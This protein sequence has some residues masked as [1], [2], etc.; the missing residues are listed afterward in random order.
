MVK[1]KIDVSESDPEEAKAAGSFEA[2]KPG[3]Y[4]FEIAEVNPGFS[5]GD[6]GKPDNNKPRLEVVFK[7]L[8]SRFKGAQV[9]GYF[10]Q[11]GHP[12][13]DKKAAEKFDQLLLAVKFTDGKKNR[14]AELDTDKHLVGKKVVVR[15]RAGKNQSGDARGEFGSVFP[16]ETSTGSSDTTSATGDDEMIEGD[17]IVADEIDWDAR[18]ADLAGADVPSLKAIAK[19]YEVKITGMKKSEVVDAILEYE[20]ANVSDDDEI[21]DDDDEIIPDDDEDTTEYLT[22][23]GL[24]AMETS[25]I[26]RIAKED[27][28]LTIKGKRK[29]EVIDMIIEAQA[30]PAD[31]GDE[32]PF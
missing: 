14:V 25:E 26:A 10:I 30:A 11:K 17:D 1:I 2:I 29:S 3:L 6:D 32:E 28:D 15:V 12:G 19:E 4:Q 20:K 16:P 5:K 7:C 21:L 13:Y 31:A 24:A 9:W 22:R 8:D 27:F 23:E 18:K